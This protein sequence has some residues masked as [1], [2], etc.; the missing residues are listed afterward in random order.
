MTKQAC[1]ATPTAARSGRDDA[2]RHVGSALPDRSRPGHRRLARLERGGSIAMVT[3][4]T[5]PDGSVTLDGLTLRT[6]GIRGAV[7]VDRI[8][9]PGRVSGGGAAAGTVA[10]PLDRA[11]RRQRMRT[12]RHVTVEG[13]RVAAAAPAAG[14][15][16]VPRRGPER[17]LRAR[18]RS[19]DPDRAGPARRSR[20]GRAR[21]RQR[22]R[23][24]AFQRGIALGR[25]RGDRFRGRGPT[26]SRRSA[27]R[28]NDSRGAALSIGSLVI[29]VITFPVAKLVGMAARRLARDWDT[30]HHPSQVRAY[31]P[32]GTLTD[33][34]AGGL[35]SARRRAGAAVRP[36]HV[37]HDRGRL[38][39]TAA[40]RR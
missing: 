8:A 17:G 3:T 24:V 39:P 25:P 14:A 2:S 15:A 37:Q 12:Y 28:P 1:S 19:A 40:R 34:A 30:G 22:R 9:P 29:K 32:D 16:R 36:R 11:L 6:P 4:A 27:R 5:D 33:L 13:T 21:R 31:G 23:D 26:S 38:R 18:T 35:G 20:P 10:D 7:S